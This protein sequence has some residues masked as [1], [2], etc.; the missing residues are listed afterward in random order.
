MQTKGHDASL[1]VRD[2]IL[3]E[4]LM[5]VFS[6][7]PKDACCLLLLMPVAHTSLGAKIVLDAKSV[8]DS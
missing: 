2:G 4:L 5:I 3:I 7:L 8:V 1:Y 6:L